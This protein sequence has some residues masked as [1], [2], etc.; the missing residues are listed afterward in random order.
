MLGLIFQTCRIKQAQMLKELEEAANEVKIVNADK[1]V[2][3]PLIVSYSL[4]NKVHSKFVS[5]LTAAL[6]Y[7]L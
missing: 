2:Q 5:W 7:H 6:K 4:P 3:E 1:A